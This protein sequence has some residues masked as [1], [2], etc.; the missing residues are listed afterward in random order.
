M[1]VFGTVCNTLN[2]AATVLNYVKAVR[3]GADERSKLLTEISSLR[4]VLSVLDVCIRNQPDR[5]KTLFILFTPDGPLDQCNLVLQ[6]L[7]SKLKPPVTGTRL[8]WRKKLKWPWER[9]EVLE[10][11]AQIERL[12]SLITLMLTFTSS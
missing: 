9:T 4:A 12:K 2:L 3:G 11:L 10:S 7:E 8:G 1:D 5:T 6:E